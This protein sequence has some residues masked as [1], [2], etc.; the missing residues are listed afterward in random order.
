[1]GIFIEDADRG[2]LQGDGQVQQIGVTGD[3]N[4]AA[5][6][7]GRNT[8]QILLLEN[9]RFHAGEESNDDGFADACGS[10]NGDC[11]GSGSGATATP[12]R[13]SGRTAS[14]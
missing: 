11:T 10:C 7:Q 2:Y 13:L 12:L 9:L 6:Q 1:M 4:L 3:E 8:G 14:I 5:F